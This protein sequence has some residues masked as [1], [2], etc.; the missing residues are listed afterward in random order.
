[1][2]RAVIALLLSLAVLVTP[3]GALAVADEYD[4]TQSHPLRVATYLIYP[5]GYALE[6]IIFRPF[7]FVVASAGPLFGHV[8]HGESHVE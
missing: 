4:D 1:M 7:H 8:P 5:V 2:K 6:W 3:I